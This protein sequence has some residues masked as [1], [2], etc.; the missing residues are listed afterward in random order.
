MINHASMSVIYAGNGLTARAASQ[1]ITTLILENAVSFIGF[2]S[3]IPSAELSVPRVHLTLFFSPSAYP[4]PHPG[5]L[6]TFNVSS[7]MRRHYRN[8]EFLANNR[9]QPQPT[10]LQTSF[11]SP[12]LPPDLYP[13]PPLQWGFR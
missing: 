5:C 8:H 11:Y 4:C 6:R 1:F 7:N 3:S 13:P 2:F 10:N 9:P 12:P